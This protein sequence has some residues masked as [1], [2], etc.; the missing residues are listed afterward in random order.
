MIATHLWAKRKVRSDLLR[1]SPFSTATHQAQTTKILDDS[2]Q[3]A[4]Q[5]YVGK[6]AFAC[7]ADAS[8]ETVGA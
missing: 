5:T 1:P 6:Q 4:S 3:G 2:G 7:G 8:A